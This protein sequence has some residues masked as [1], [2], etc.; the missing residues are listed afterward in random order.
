M[1]AS[2]QRGTVIAKGLKIEG[3][4]LLPRASLRSMV[5][6][7]ASFTALLS[8][9]MRHLTYRVERRQPGTRS[10]Q[11]LEV[12]SSLPA[13]RPPKIHSRQFA[14]WAYPTVRSKAYDPTLGLEICSAGCSLRTASILHTFSREA[15]LGGAGELFIR[16][17]LFA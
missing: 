6:L 3:S 2:R 9:I 16:R 17:C 4:A 13:I 7:R 5:K 1:F 11:A 14:C 12:W 15:R 10:S 8:R